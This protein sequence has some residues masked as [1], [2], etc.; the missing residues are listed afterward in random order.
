MTARPFRRVLVTNRG[1]IALRIV[2][3]CRDLGLESVAV[4]AVD[5][6]EAP[7]VRH[8]DRAVDLGGA[9]PADTYL[10][11][12]KIIAVAQ[13]VGADAVHP[14]Y[15]FLSENADFAQA[16]LDAGLVWIGPAPGVIRD[17]G[18]KSTAR[19]IAE[20]AGVPLA[21]GSSEPV[22]DAD[23]AVAFAERHGLPVVIKAAYGGG[24][25]GMRVARELAEVPDLFAAAVSEALSAFG[26]GECLVERYL[27]R[28]R[29]V[30]AQVLADTHGT[31]V[32]V[33]DRDCTLQRRHQKLVEEAPAPFLT[34]TQR[35]TVHDSAIALCQ[36]A[37]YVGAGTVE[38]LLD[39]DGTLSFLE[40]NTRLQVEHTVTEETTGLDLVAEQLRVA[41]GEALQVDRHLAPTR[42]SLEFRINAEDPTRGFLPSTGTL[43]RFEASS[44]PGIRIDAGVRVGSEVSGR[45]DSMLA[46]LVVT[47]ADRPQALARARRAFSEFDISGVLTIVPFLRTVLDHPAFVADD[48]LGIHTRWIE[49]ELSAQDALTPP[50]GDEDSAAD[51]GRVAVQVGA[52]WMEI[53]VPGLAQAESGPLVQ[54]RERGRMRRT[55]ATEQP[56][57]AVV[58]QMQGTVVQVAAAEGDLVQQGDVVVVVEAMKMAN[59][60]TAPQ[61]GQVTGLALTVGD[62]VSQGAIICRITADSG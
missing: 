9:G 33:G 57:D 16:V 59:P 42:H 8:A 4:Y 5:D 32:T 37:G 58:A 31:V 3:A 61:P 2:R 62:G 29:H 21:P 7:F 20:K 53:S 56:R 24:G 41:A 52:R 30:E 27:D 25:R 1:E 43:T 18:D 23:E 54:A 40:V 46:K 6:A 60:L 13:E 47:G 11:I 12:D 19:L 22:A 48:H 50:A 35:R 38:Y 10:N 28:A 17:L 49:D 14:G 15:G 51:L 55:R 36:E 45:F 44:G 39:S 26:R 34:E